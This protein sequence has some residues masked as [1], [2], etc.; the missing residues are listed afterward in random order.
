MPAIEDES[1][2]QLAG[3]NTPKESSNSMPQP[4][5]I[6]AYLIFHTILIAL[7]RLGMGA[8]L[9]IAGPSLPVMR[10]RI[11][12]N[13]EGISQGLI[14]RSVGYFMGAIVGGFM[15]DYFYRS[16]DLLLG[17][18]LLVAAI[19]TIVAPWSRWIWLFGIMLHLQGWSE[20]ILDTAGDAL[21]LAM[22]GEK[23]PAPVHSLHLAFGIGA[24]LAPQIAA[25]FLGPNI[26]KDSAGNDSGNAT[27]LPAM[28]NSTTNVTVVYDPWIDSTIQWAW[29]IIGIFVFIVGVVFVALH[30]IGPPKGYQVKKPDQV[31]W[32]VVHPRACTKGKATWIF[33]SGLLVFLFMF[34]II[35]VGGERVYSK[36]LFTF[37][38][39]G[40]VPSF[41]NQDAAFLVSVF[42]LCFTAGRFTAMLTAIVCPPWIMLLVEA[43][44]NIAVAIFLNVFSHTE[45]LALWVLS[46]ALGFFLSPVFP[47]GVA[48]ASKYL[49]LTGMAMTMMYIGAATG[50]FIFQY[51]TGALFDIYG[52][53]CMMGIILAYAILISSVIV[54]MQV[55]SACLGKAATEFTG[56][57]P[58]EHPHS[59][60]GNHPSVKYEVPQNLQETH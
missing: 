27:S 45:P 35:I 52:P 3:V 50:G 34:Y 49:I 28:L 29:L 25:P 13:Y 8:Y 48:W 51:L 41:S 36:Y 11:G 38:T 4:R 47:T 39:E 12:T 26:P 54:A 23:A 60:S 56:E 7:A 57:Q 15:K 1:E 32:K 58:E 21:V 17:V 2:K 18:A 31:I 33:S 37:A 40:V 14:A 24:L 43:G 42:W 55:Y 19:A 10:S 6:S 22:W 46:G 53:G 30:L 59:P 20:G 9:E 16:N 5:P 44:F